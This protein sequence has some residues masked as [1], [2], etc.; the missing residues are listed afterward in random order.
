MFSSV[1]S[2]AILGVHS[3]LLQIE[4][5]V[6]DG[7]PTFTMVGFLSAQVKES[8]ERVRVA[9]RSQGIHLPPR[10]ITVNCTPADLPKRGLLLDL[11]VACGLLACLGIVESSTLSDVFIA[12]GL[13]LDGEVTP[14]RGI[15]P[16]V[17][18][19]YKG[20]LKRCLLP[21]ENV[22]EGAAVQGIDCIGVASLAE[23][24][25]YL[26]LPQ[27]QRDQCFPPQQ[28]TS[29]EMSSGACLQ[30]GIPDFGDVRGQEGVKRAME[31]AAAGFHNLLMVGPPGS[32]KS[33]MAKCLPGILPPL[34]PEESLEVSA[35]YSIAGELPKG[36]A[37]ITR[38]PYLTPHH[39]DSS[40]PDRRRQ[41]SQAGNALPRAQRC[42]LSR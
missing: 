22:Q 33:M 32:G 11:P 3:Y 41:L 27:Q 31:I 23:V 8:G 10:R 39:T 13:S 40:G 19:A 25:Q 7:L 4:T 34:S 15:L 28:R 36:Q 5:D 14:V 29:S 26:T 37:L 35:I 1:Y 12:G 6:S 18:E 20:G 30:E 24:I 9:L 21:K 17:Q 42:T 2:G 38:R 16:M